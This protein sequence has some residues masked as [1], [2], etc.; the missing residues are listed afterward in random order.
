MLFVW[1]GSVIP[2]ILP[3]L[4]VLFVW[5]SLVVASHGVW[6]PLP[7]HIGPESLGLLGVTLAIFLGFRNTTSYERFWEA[8][9]LWGELLNAARAFARQSFTLP[10]PA[11]DREE[12]RRVAVLLAA[13]AHTLNEQLRR[14]SLSS[15]RGAPD[16]HTPSVNVDAEPSAFRARLVDAAYK[17]LTVIQ[18]LSVLVRE[19][20]RDGRISSHVLFAMDRNL[21]RLIDV[22]GGCERIASTPIPFVYGVLL[23]RTVYMYSALL[24]FALVE[25]LGW[26]TPWVEVLICYT[27]VALDR[28]TAELEDPFG[29]EGNDLPLDAMTRNVER[30]VLELAGEP[31]PPPHRPDDDFR[32]T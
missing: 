7:L 3:R 31:L 13:V 18:E 10:E 12:R 32:L 23:H 5:A 11:L 25:A 2:Q 28:V 19:L 27:F 14:E 17:P 8:R 22:V 16:P 30:S 15:E 1:R 6:G 26:S 4:G 29:T 24:P 9:T 20:R 21:D